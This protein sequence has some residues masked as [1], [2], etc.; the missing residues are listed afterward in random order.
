MI[1]STR[2]LSARS[3]ICFNE[4]LTSVIDFSATILAICALELSPTRNRNALRSTSLLCARPSLRFVSRTLRTDESSRAS[5]YL[6]SETPAITASIAL[7]T[8]SG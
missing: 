3:G 1:E 6:P 2:A 8:S 7:E 5:V 4:S